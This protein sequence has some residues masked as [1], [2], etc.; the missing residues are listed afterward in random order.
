MTEKKNTKKKGN[1]K[2]RIRKMTENPGREENPLQMIGG[3]LGRAVVDD[4]G[5]VC[6]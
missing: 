5:I 1:E 6:L 4:P 2:I 3:L